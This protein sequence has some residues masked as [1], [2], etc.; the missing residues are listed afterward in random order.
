M[1][2]RE[3]IQAIVGKFSVGEEV[4]DVIMLDNG[5]GDADMTSD[6]TAMVKRALVNEFYNILQVSKVTEG[7]Y[8]MSYDLEAMKLWYTTM[9]KELGIKDKLSPRVKSMGGVSW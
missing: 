7:G 8:G 9:C 3:Y 5:F 6:D 2:I 1:K 4:V